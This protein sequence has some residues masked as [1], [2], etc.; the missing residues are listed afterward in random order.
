MVLSVVWEQ[1]V[2]IASFAIPL[3]LGSLLL[4]IRP[5]LVLVVV[6]AACVTGVLGVSG[7]TGCGCRS[8]RCS[9][10]RP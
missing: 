9:R 4:Q 3:L 7:A 8:R 10:W 1:W 6:Q 5:F 2:P